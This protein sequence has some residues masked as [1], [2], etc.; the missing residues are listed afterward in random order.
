MQPDLFSRTGTLLNM[1]A[2]PDVL[3]PQARGQ[4]N[5][6][7][8]LFAATGNAQHLMQLFS[9]RPNEPALPACTK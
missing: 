9:S 1:I 6:Q 3:P 2:R 5:M 7:P 4:H 8:D